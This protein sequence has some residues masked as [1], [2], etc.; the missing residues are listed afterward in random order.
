MSRVLSL[1][2]ILSVMGMPWKVYPDDFNWE[3]VTYTINEYSSKTRT[4]LPVLYEYVSKHYSEPKR[5]ITI[6]QDTVIAREFK[7]L[8]DYNALE[9][10]V[11]DM[12]I[13][14]LKDLGVTTK[15]LEVIVAPGCGKFLNKGRS[16][17][18]EVDICGAV[19]DFYY[20]LFLKLSSLLFN[21]VKWRDSEELILHLD[22]SHGV[23][24]MPALTRAIIPE[25]LSIV[26]AYTDLRKVKLRVYNSE[27]V[28]KGVPKDNYTIHLVE[29]IN[30]K[31]GGSY[32]LTPLF[33]G[34]KGKLRLFSV[35]GEQCI[36]KLTDPRE[37]GI[38]IHGLSENVINE[39]K[40][41]SA[42]ELNMFIGSLVNGLPLLVL[43][44]LPSLS[45]EHFVEK[46]LGVYKELVVMNCR[47]EGDKVFIEITRKAKMTEHV[48]ILA[49]IL[50]VGNLI[51]L[52]IRES[53]SDDEGISLEQLKDLINNL[54][55]WNSRLKTIIGFDYIV[56]EKMINAIRSIRELDGWTSPTY[57]SELAEQVEL[58]TKGGCE[59][60]LSDS[61]D[62]FERNFLQ[63]SGLHRCV[64]EVNVKNR[65]IRYTKNL[66]DNIVDK[67]YKAATRGLVLI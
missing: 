26:A 19:S 23:N 57:Y 16:L 41:S 36:K 3:E 42:K 49:K 30:V 2:V 13:E 17:S 59:E 9:S 54:Y 60:E 44:T 10:T 45:L 12:Y 11:K 40:I 6:V 31:E 7:P 5:I 29:E 46:T 50:L 51:M 20:Y 14:F 61:S 64:I 22:L 15:N 38:V 43:K 52:K 62:R 18:I 4:T 1:N 63:H 21:V 25:I 28:V 47:R 56:L 33:E 34:V 55:T 32:G 58:I 24:Y 53:Y 37:I 35:S 39:L 65:R 27:P 48:K 66:Q 67:I 8:N